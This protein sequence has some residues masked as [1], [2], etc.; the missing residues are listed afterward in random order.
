MCWMYKRT[1]KQPTA[2]N[3][4]KVWEQPWVLW[5]LY[6]LT[7]IIISVQ[8]LALTVHTIPRSISQYENYVIFKNSFGHLAAGLNPYAPFPAEQ[9]DLFKYSPAFALFMAPF[10]ALPDYLGLPI[11]NLLNTMLPI[12]ALFA[13]PVLTKR[14]KIFCGW[15]LLP[16]MVVSQQN[17]Q[18]NGLTLGLMLLA[19]VAFERAQTFKAA[20]WISAATFIKL[21]GIFAAPFTLVY[22]KKWSF[23]LWMGFWTILLAFIPLLIVSPAQLA[24]LYEWW[25]NLLSED[26]SASIGLSVQGWLESWFGWNPPKTAITLTGIALLFASI[27][28][29]ALRTHDARDRILL[30]ASLLLWVVIFNHKAESPTFIIAMCGAALWYGTTAR[31]P[32]ETVLLGVIFFMSSVTPTDIFPRVIREQIVQPYALKA[33]PCIALWGIITFRILFPGKPKQ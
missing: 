10:Q 13:L 12:A 21:F 11:W 17:S 8:R 2:T 15:F 27:L 22:T 33:V 3:V 5:G 6:A 18:S 32:W 19:F 29:T 24:Q 23:L 16:E 26:H 7:G 25:G 1:K 4:K 28:A 30:W 9:W 14:Q 31:K 20:G